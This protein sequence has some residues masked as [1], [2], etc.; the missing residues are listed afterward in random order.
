M[1][2]KYRLPS[3]ELRTELKNELIKLIERFN[4]ILDLSLI[5]FP[6]NYESIL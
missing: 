3:V 4:D 1:I 5:G 2:L 6:T